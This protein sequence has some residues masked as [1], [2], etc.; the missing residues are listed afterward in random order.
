MQGLPTFEHDRAKADR[1]ST[2]ML[3]PWIHAGG[4]SVRHVYY[5]VAQ[6]HAE[7]QALAAAAGAGGGGTAGAGGGGGGGG[8]GGA[9]GSGAG[10]LDFVQ[11]LG[12]REYSR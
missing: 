6:K 9:V 8:G 2:T 11:Q 7:W 3:S 5:R 1:E 4:V 12:Y 10:C